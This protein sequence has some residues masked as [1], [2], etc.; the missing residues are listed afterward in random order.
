MYKVL[1]AV[2]GA[3]LLIG[4]MS[5]QSPPTAAAESWAI[6]PVHSTALF[7]IHHAGAGRFWGRF[8]DVTGSVDWPRDDSAAPDSTSRWLLRVL[9]PGAR[10]LT[11]I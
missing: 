10:N 7:R 2:S 5:M 9:T 8:N 3:V 1:A 4:T 11:G 6:D